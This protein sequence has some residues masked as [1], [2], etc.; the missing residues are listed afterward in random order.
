MRVLIVGG[1]EVP[2]KASH[3]LSQSYEPVQAVSRPRMG[4]GS[5]M[6]QTAWAGKL[7]TSISGDGLIPP[8]LQSIDYSQA[9]VIKCVAERVVTSA[10]NVIAVPT[11][12]RADYGVEGRALVGSVWQSTPAA[13]VG[14][15]ATLTIAASATAY[16]AIYWPELICFC[17]PPTD[18]RAVRSSGY[19]WSLIGEEI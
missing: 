18:N 6:Q 12:R 7:L 17:D 9:V 15:T 19:S 8:G 16:Q 13:V 1:I 14:D 5:L 11:G 10:S 2:L 4:D 3:V